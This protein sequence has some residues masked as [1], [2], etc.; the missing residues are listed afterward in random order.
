MGTTKK[1]KWD[2]FNGKIRGNEKFF[3][4]FGLT[5]KND[6]LAIIYIILY[7]IFIFIFNFIIY[8]ILNLNLSFFFFS[9]LVVYFIVQI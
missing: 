9:L 8:Y 7:F 6:T 1:C 3:I 5:Q 2:F 4:I